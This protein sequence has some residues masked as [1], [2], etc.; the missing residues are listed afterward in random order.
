MEIYTFMVKYFYVIIF[1]FITIIIVLAI[2]RNAL[3]PQKLEFVTQEE[4]EELLFLIREINQNND[5]IHSLS[6]SKVKIYL[7]KG[8]WIKTKAKLYFKQEK[9]IRIIIENFFGKQIDIGSNEELFWFWSSYMTPPTYYFSRHQDL[10]KTNLKTPLNPNWI[11]ESMGFKSIEVKN[12]VFIKTEQ[13][14]G[15]KQIRSSSSGENISIITLIDPLKRI[16]VKKFLCDSDNQVIATVEYKNYI[17][18]DD[19]KIPD[20]IIINWYSENIFM[21]WKIT[22]IKLNI[23]IKEDIWIMPKSN[24]SVSLSEN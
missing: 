14:Q 3:N 17:S 1:L 9:N 22:E 5:R 8:F 16:V 4:N 11:I 21:E 24:N 18:I 15:I 12:I 10:N 6:Y 13:Y 23:P 19:I 20:H 7:K 2:K